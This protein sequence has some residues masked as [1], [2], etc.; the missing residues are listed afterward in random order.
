VRFLRRSEY[1][2]E[3]RSLRERLEEASRYRLTPGGRALLLAI[4]GAE[5]CGSVSIDA[6]IFRLFLGLLFLYVV[7]FFCGF[8]FK[9]RVS[10]AGGLPER[11]RVGEPF[12]ARCQVT[13]LSSFL[14]CF[15]LSLGFLRKPSCFD[16]VS[17]GTIG[18]LPPKATASV[19]LTCR[20][21][22]RGLHWIPGLRPYTVFPFNTHLIASEAGPKRSILAVPGFFPLRS[23]VLPAGSRHQPGGIAFSLNLGDSPEYVGSREYQPG[24]PNP[25][26]D[27][28]SWARLA[29]PV[30]REFQEEYYCRLALVLDTWTGPCRHR[31]CAEDLESAVSLSAAAAEF[32]TRGEYI[33]ELLAAG[34]H[35]Y[36]FRSGRGTSHFDN[37]LDILAC[38]EAVSFCPFEL[39]LPPLTQEAERISACLCF[40]LDWDFAREQFIRQVEA[41]GIPARVVVLRSVPPTCQ[42]PS[43]ISLVSPEAV[44]AGEVSSL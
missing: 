44:R 6:P 5:I 4:I 42:V 36:Q 7:S 22:T 14:P 13:N 8:L 39:I 34:P 23:V 20:C 15:D 17:S 41:A 10:V 29:R 21:R 9:P 16:E 30:V 31:G 28:R 12:A 11:V 3:R 32:L 18:F 25:R 37:I 19:S 33:V 24:E 40:F 43:G 26:F 2:S 35:L 1:R 38:V 27:F